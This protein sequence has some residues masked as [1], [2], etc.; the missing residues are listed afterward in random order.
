MAKKSHDTPLLDELEKGPWPSFVTGLKRLAKDKDEVV[1]LLDHL[2]HSYRTKLGH[3]KGGTVGV[4]GYGGGVIPRFSEI[5]D[6]S[7]KPV[8]PKAA[9]F[10]TLRVM[11]PSG[12]HYDTATLRKICDIWERHASGLIALHGQS[13][14]IMFQGATG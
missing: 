6:E 10:H 13:G 12:M 7:G 2:E 8:Y 14:D 1:D 3:W 9:E 4:Y 11:P 5:K